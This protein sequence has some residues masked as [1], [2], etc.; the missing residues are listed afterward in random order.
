[1]AFVV[2]LLEARGVALGF[3]YS[4]AIRGSR[5][6]LDLGSTE[7]LPDCARA[8]PELSIVPIA[9]AN[10]P[11]RGEVRPPPASAQYRYRER[12]VF[13]GAECQDNN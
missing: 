4:S 11:G 13:R 3:P 2:R 1:V 9:E 7:A 6:R 8:W 10:T 12:V 5:L